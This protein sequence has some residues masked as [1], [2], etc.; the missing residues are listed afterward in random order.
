M[1]DSDDVLEKEIAAST[2]VRLYVMILFKWQSLFRISDNGIAML[3]LLLATFLKVLSRFLQANII[4]E[5]ADSLP[6]TLHMAK[7]ILGG[8]SDPFVKYVSCPTCKSLYSIKDCQIVL[9]DK[10]V[11]SKKCSHVEFPAHP[12]L[13]RR[14]PCDVILLKPVRTSSGTTFPVIYFA[15][16]NFE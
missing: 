11:V 7:G 6:K 16:G 3:F 4:C 5:F 13:A 12:H 9:P 8:K 1:D 2:I 14:R 10:T 15:I